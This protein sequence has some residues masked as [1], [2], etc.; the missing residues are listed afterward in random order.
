MPEASD[1][2][3]A[4]VTRHQRLNNMNN[5]VAGR[6]S[7]LEIVDDDWA[8]DKLSDDE[9]EIGRHE[10]AVAP[11]LEEGELDADAIVSPAGNSSTALSSSER[12]RREEG[13]NDLALEQLGRTTNPISATVPTTT[14]RNSNP[15]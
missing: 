9:V 4:A 10:L 8:A 1:S 14:N 2:S 3:Y 11:L 12:R 15:S 7:A 6:P 5:K 13:W